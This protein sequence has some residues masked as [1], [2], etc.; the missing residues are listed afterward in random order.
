MASVIQQ[1]DSQS[2]KGQL[3]GSLNDYAFDEVDEEI[4]HNIF[5]D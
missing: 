1:V 2:G 3:E 4:S 5:E